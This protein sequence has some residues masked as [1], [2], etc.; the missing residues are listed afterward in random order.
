MLEMELLSKYNSS[1]LFPFIFDKGS[2]DVILFSL[3]DN[4]DNEG[5]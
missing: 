2:K 4:L 1:N 3:K 5:K